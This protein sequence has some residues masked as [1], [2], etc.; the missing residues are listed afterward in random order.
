[1]SAI[2]KIASYVKKLWFFD[3]RTHIFL[4]CKM[5][6]GLECQGTFLKP[7]GCSAPMLGLGGLSGICRQF[8]T[9]FTFH[10]LI[11]SAH[12]I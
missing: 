10:F 12:D 3:T 5:T 4:I 6:K 9:Q 11:F 7:S 2:N 8:P 1:M